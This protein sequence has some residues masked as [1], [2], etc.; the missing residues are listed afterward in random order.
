MPGINSSISQ[1]GQAINNVSTSAGNV[2]SA[3]GNM[4]SSFDY[5][6]TFHPPTIS[7]GEFDLGKF[8]SSGFKE[9]ISLPDIKWTISGE[10]GETVKTFASSLN[11]IRGFCFKS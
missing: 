8:I 11:R 4:I 9:G 5:T 6:I 2:I 10:G 1:L 7:G 3:L